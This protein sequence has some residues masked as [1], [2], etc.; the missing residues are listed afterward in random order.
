METALPSRT[1]RYADQR[2]RLP[3]EGRQVIAAFDTSS[4]VV[5]QAYKPAIAEWVIEQQQ[6]GGPGYSMSR[7]TWIKPSFLWMM[8][9]SGWA[10]RKDQ[11]R[12]LAIRARRPVF[13]DFV[14]QAVSTHRKVT[15]E[16]GEDAS[17]QQPRAA[18]VLVQWD[19]DRHP[20]G[21]PLPRKAIQLGLRAGALDRFVDRGC[22]SIHDVTAF[23]RAQ[24]EVFLSSGPDDVLVPVVTE[25]PRR[26]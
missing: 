15:G 12:V 1:E 4:V 3:Q 26:E 22:A 20:D 24:H 9:R 17:D 8:Y 13:D 7:M 16:H 5:Y 10:T 6:L 2:S 25:Y 14:A 23:V 18:E 19:P 21:S 11:E